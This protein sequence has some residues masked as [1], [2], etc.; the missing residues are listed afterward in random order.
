[1]TPQELD[2]LIEEQ[3][4]DTSTSGIEK[5]KQLKAKI[6][7]DDARFIVKKQIVPFTRWYL[8]NLKDASEINI[9]IGD[10]IE[11]I[12]LEQS[13]SHDNIYK[14]TTRNV[15]LELGA[16]FIKLKTPDPHALLIT[17][18]VKV[19]TVNKPLYKNEFNATEELMNLIREE[20][21]MKNENT[22]KLTSAVITTALIAL[23]VIVIIVLA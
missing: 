21:K 6:E 3:K 11:L 22:K 14:G 4:S 9:D 20:T 23:I 8:E 12:D 7:N 10:Q 2:K 17:E 18:G 5:C 1:M 19:F 16:N 13:F 15:V